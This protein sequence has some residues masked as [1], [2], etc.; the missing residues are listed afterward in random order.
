MVGN[1]RPGMRRSRLMF[2][3]V[4]TSVRTRGCLEMIYSFP[5]LGVTGRDRVW[6]STNP[7]WRRWSWS[8]MVATSLVANHSSN[9][10]FLIGGGAQC[11]YVKPSTLWKEVW[12]DFMT[13][14]FVTRIYVNIKKQ[15]AYCW[16]RCGQIVCVTVLNENFLRSSS[17]RPS[18]GLCG[19]CKNTISKVYFHVV[20]WQDNGFWPHDRRFDPCHGNHRVVWALTHTTPTNIAH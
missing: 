10:C 14:G 4:W 15:Y 9:S 11:M 5:G 6:E 2:L 19:S 8:K 1:K 16:C 17:K 20:K 12:E 18:F 3:R 13:K 7:V